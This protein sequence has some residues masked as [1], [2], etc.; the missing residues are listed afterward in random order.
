[1]RAVAHQQVDF[2][3]RAYA[4][5]NPCGTELW[6]KAGTQQGALAFISTACDCHKSPNKTIPCTVLL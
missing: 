3:E 4:A 6:H 5:T 1:M 2:E